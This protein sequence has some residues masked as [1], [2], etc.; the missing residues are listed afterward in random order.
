MK[1]V[2]SFLLVVATVCF[3]GV[4]V[5]DDNITWTVGNSPDII[6]DADGPL[7]FD[8]TKGKGFTYVEIKTSKSK[9]RIYPCGKIEK[10]EWKEIHPNEKSPPDLVRQLN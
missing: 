10:L 2:I 6:F 1:K 3:G 8:L 5:S 4:A 9:F 7:H